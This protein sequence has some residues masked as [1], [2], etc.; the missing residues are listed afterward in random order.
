MEK[1]LTKHK[2]IYVT[3]LFGIVS[4]MILWAA[5]MTYAYDEKT[6][7]VNSNSVNVRKGAGTSYDKLTYGGSNV[8]L[9]KGTE[10]KVVGESKATDGA[11]WYKVR[12]D[13]NGDTL[14]GYVHS[15]Y[16]NIKI[17][18]TPDTDFEEYLKSQNFPA[19]YKEGLRE[20]HAKYPNWVFVADHVEYKWSEVLKNESAIGMS[21][22]SKTAISSYKSTDPKA[23]NWETGT[24]YNFD[25]T[26]WAAA[27]E[28]L[29]AYSLDPRN[30]LNESGIFMFECLSYDEKIH[31]LA[32]IRE[33]IKD[34]FM[35]GTK[36][37]NGKYYS[38]VLLQAAR[39]YNVSPYTLAIR[40]IQEQGT[41]GV[42]RCIS[43]TVAGYEGYYNYFDVGAFAANGNNA[44][45]NGLIYAKGGKD[46]TATSYQRPWNRRYKSILGGAQYLASGY[47]AQGQDTLYYEKFDLVGVPYT[48]QY[49]THILGPKLESDRLSK[50]YTEDTMK[51][52][53]FVF[54]IPVYKSMPTKACPRPTK[55][56]SPNNALKSLTVSGQKLSPTFD[57]FTHSYSLIVDNE[58]E[59]ITVKANA[60]DTKAKIIGTGA[61]KLSVGTN[62]ISVKVMAE[63]GDIRTYKI[64]VVREEA[65]VPPV[66]V[67][68]TY[69]LDGSYVS[70]VEPGTT[71]KKAL[72]KFTIKNG[73]A[74]IVNK[75]GKKT[76]DADY[77]ATGYKCVVYDLNSNKY[78][79]YTFVIYGDISGDGKIDADDMIYIK[80]HIMGKQ[81][82]KGVMLRAADA[83]RSSDGVTP[84]DM[85]KVKLHILEKERIVQ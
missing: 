49:M 66:S 68:C 53:A 82:L 18:Y 34:T 83:D 56:G 42:G 55:D 69:K 35:S 3:F 81:N 36:L 46:G 57:K 24:W 58:V 29:V 62:T 25:G 12:F 59:S 45:I 13:K 27:S 26:A 43:G 75:S 2:K 67:K 5:N 10:V 41:N 52:T 23:Y 17:E 7:T 50:S 60:Y 31:T 79:T 9:N 74:I 19:S 4:M 63:N 72:S 16:V 20:L 11:L 33:V 39:D 51:N 8:Q 14:T 80:L 30:F 37:E 47:I 78:K 73:T 32:G 77:V 40:I 22:I 64:K 71:V 61:K 1:Q 65:K 28:E 48:H 21:L 84:I 85:L 70:G 54:K 76:A 6:G 15:D 44:I 38:S